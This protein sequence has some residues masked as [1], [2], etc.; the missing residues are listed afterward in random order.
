LKWFRGELRG[1]IDELLN[2]KFIRTQGIFKY[3]AI[4]IILKQMHS[5]S[6]GDSVAR[7]WALIVFQTWWKKYFLNS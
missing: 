4:K 1:L 3:S 2:E 7:I 6:P 5:A